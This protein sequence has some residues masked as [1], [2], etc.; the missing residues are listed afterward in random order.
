MPHLKSPFIYFGGKSSIADVIWNF[1]GDGIQNY[2]EP[3]FGSGAVLLSRPDW[4]TGKRLTETINDADGFLANFWRALQS[5]PDGVAEYADW[6]VNESDLEARHLWLV[7]R[8]K[9]LTDKLNDPDFYDVKFAGWWVWGI[10]CWIGSGWCSGE[11]PW[12]YDENAKK[13]MDSRKLPHLGDDGRGVHRKLPHLGDDGRGVHRQLPHLGNDGR[14]VHRQ[15]PHLGD[16][17]RGLRDYLGQ[18]AQRLR[19]VRVC[20]GDWSRIMGPTVTVG[21]GITAVFLDPPYSSE[22][23]RDMGCYAVDCGKIAHDV[24]KWCE[25]NGDDPRLRICLAG[26]EGE[27]HEALVRKGWRVQAWKASGG[28]ENQSHGDAPGNCRKERLWFSPGCIRKQ[29]EMF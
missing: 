21:H 12:I 27:G 17:G 5:D 16:D 20:C 29:E 15:L 18:L 25:D 13:I 4:T 1:F 24:R 7:N 10:N 19:W 2:V 28:Y 3:F 14:G 11:G 26:Y 6:P 8:R 9:A 23:N 22:A